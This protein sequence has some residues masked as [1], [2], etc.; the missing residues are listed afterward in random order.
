[1][2]WRKQEGKSTRRSRIEIDAAARRKEEFG[3]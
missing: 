1:M 2:V 3:L